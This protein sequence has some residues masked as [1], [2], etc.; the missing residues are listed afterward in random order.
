MGTNKVLGMINIIYGEIYRISGGALI[1]LD[2]LLKSIRYFLEHKTLYTKED[3]IKEINKILK[4]EDIDT[5]NISH[6]QLNES[7]TKEIHIWMDERYKSEKIPSYDFYATLG[8]ANSAILSD[9]SIIHTGQ[10]SICTTHNIGAG[11][12]MFVHMLNGEIVE[13]KFGYNEK[14][15]MEIRLDTNLERLLL[16]NGFGLAVQGYNIMPI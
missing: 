12:K 14:I 9:K 6:E 3:I 7:D 1:N 10:T 5:E 11:Y 8:E 16:R 15:N 2:S 4:D 13:I